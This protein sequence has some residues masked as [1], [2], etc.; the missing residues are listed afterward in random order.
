MSQRERMSKA[1]GAAFLSHKVAELEKSVDSLA[2]SRDAKLYSDPMSRGRGRGHAT[3]TG[4]DGSTPSAQK[5]YPHGRSD[6]MLRPA[7]ARERRV[8]DASALVHALPVLKRWIRQDTY[9]LIVPLQV[10]HS[11]AFSTLDILKKAPNPLHDLVREA[12]K[13]LE[14]QLN[15]AKQIEATLGAVEARARVRLRAQ[16]AEEE[17]PWTT[18]ERM[19]RVPSGFEVYQNESELDGYADEGQ[20][21]PWPPR[22]PVAGD[23]PRS[24][25]STLQ[26]ALYLNQAGDT[27]PIVV[28]NKGIS[29]NPYAK[30]STAVDTQAQVKQPSN[31]DHSNHHS[32][33]KAPID[34]DAI[35]AGDATTFWLS[36]FFI[37]ADSVIDE[38]T[39]TKVNEFSGVSIDAITYDEI[40]TA[41]A[42]LKSI[43][44]TASSV[45]RSQGQSS[46]TQ[47]GGASK[48]QG[49]PAGKGD[50]VGQTQQIAKPTRTHRHGKA[51]GGGQ[52]RNQCSRDDAPSSSSFG[53]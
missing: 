42:W 47:R 21:E 4:R 13:F 24:L 53:S 26:C 41:K 22:V 43:A 11:T 49:R 35:A 32:T 20:Q 52:T 7:G 30:P 51:R 8:V 46:Q 45:N 33:N 27:T 28:H 1:M 18:L 48:G 12:T 36:T 23:I 5:G 3:G 38:T 17:L 10:R 14:A 25:R 6:A 37:G 40:Q 16:A 29:T 31:A 34:F 44:A 9:Q 19:F 39:G 15:I 50:S 2:F